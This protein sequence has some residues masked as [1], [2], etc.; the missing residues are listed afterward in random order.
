ML[1]YTYCSC[2]STALQSWCINVATA[3]PVYFQKHI[4]VNLTINAAV[5]LPNGHRVCSP[6][7]THIYTRAHAFKHS[8]HTS[9]AP[10]AHTHIHIDAYTQ[11][12]AYEQHACMRA[13][14]HTHA[15]K[16]THAYARIHPSIYVYTLIHTDM[17]TECT[18]M[19]RCAHMYI[20]PTPIYMHIHAICMHTHA[21][22]HHTCSTHA[23][24][25]QHTRA[26]IMHAQPQL[27]Y[28]CMQCALINSVASR[29]CSICV[30]M[31][32]CNNLQLIHA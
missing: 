25:T 13:W 21:H 30:G 20:A 28:A 18:C 26:C 29:V 24:H 1:P 15:H 32:A 9:H 10:Y 16:L 11:I 27:Q 23:A 19:H 7:P 3:A 31:N 12:R 8:T 14:G 17:H 6:P 22:T 5:V 2:C 4:K